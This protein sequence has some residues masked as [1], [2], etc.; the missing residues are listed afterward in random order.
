MTE[1]PLECI[2]E[3]FELEPSLLNVRRTFCS[4][5]QP[6]VGFMVLIN[7]FNYF[8]RLI[9]QVGYLKLF[10]TFFTKLPLDGWKALMQHKGCAPMK[11]LDF[12]QG[13]E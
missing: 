7:M 5:D 13:L 1:S 2:E 12:F 9:K 6:S 10:T 11:W 8:Y 4:V 3:E